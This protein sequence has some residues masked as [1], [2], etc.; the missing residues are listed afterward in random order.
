[1]SSTNRKE[2][3]N[4]RIF[5]EDK[6]DS[7]INRL[8]EAATSKSTLQQLVE[9]AWTAGPVTLFASIGAY[10]LGH[11]KALPTETL[12]FF[13]GYT[14]I[15]GLIGLGAHL[16]NRLTRD[17]KR[18]EAEA[19]LIQAIGDLPDRIIDLRDLYLSTLDT[20]SRRLESARIMLQDIDLGPRWFSAAVRSAGG[21]NRLV[22]AAE[23]IEIYHRAGMRLRAEDIYREHTDELQA[24]TRALEPSTPQ[25]A[26]S[27]TQ[28]FQG[29]RPSAKQGVVRT[30]YF[31][32]RIF[33]AIED[34]DDSLMTLNDVEE[35]LTLLFELLCGRRIPVLSFHYTGNWKMAR[36]TDRLEKERFKFR[37]ARAQGYSR[38]LA[39]ANHLNLAFDTD[40]TTVP[41]GVSGPDLLA[42]CTEQIDRLVEQLESDKASRHQ[43]DF[44]GLRRY[45]RLHKHLDKAL[46]LYHL[47]FIANR[48]TDREHADFMN[49]IAHW[50]RR[51]QSQ[52]SN[53][54]AIDTGNQGPGLKITE[55]QIYLTD[56]DKLKVVS[57]LYDAFQTVK[58]LTDSETTPR[59]RMQATKQLAIRVALSLNLVLGISRPEVQRAIYTSN[60]L[61]MG[62]FEKNLSTKTKIG[63]GEALA[64]EIEKDMRS[65]SIALVKAIHHFYGLKLNTQSQELLAERYG[66][67]IEQLQ[68]LYDEDA[69]RLDKYETLPIRPFLISKSPLRWRLALSNAKIS[70]AQH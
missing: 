16:F 30:G 58:T 23:E 48:K 65:A 34:D 1:M 13:V 64:K 44:K 55:D 12:I 68:Q 31:I 21:S 25:L 56:P 11:G 17:R 4:N 29:V 33:A 8:A 7:R 19:Q 61:N 57:G 63:W 52:P 70:R 32:D 28:R 27:I 6:A 3:I 40:G 45:R 14:V 10:Y 18:G 24:L 53:E 49:D 15:A 2:A 38:L 62:V 54:V 5:I 35:T 22:Q 59:H 51:G 39:L 50:K 36:A 66:V 47:A 9:M 69:D 37:I 60:T 41:F 26:E 67:P 43:L 20:E 42:F 46:N